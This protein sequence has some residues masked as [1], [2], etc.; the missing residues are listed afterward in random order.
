MEYLEDALRKIATMYVS[1]LK[2]N[3]AAD[4]TVASKKLLNSI[5]YRI[6]DKGFDLLSEK[7]L[8]TV[9]EGK[10]PTSKNPSPEMVR[11]IVSWMQYKRIPIR[12][13]KGRFKRQTPV[14]Y[15]RAAFGIAKQINKNQTRNKY[16]W[17]GS[18]VIDRSFRQ[19]EGKIDEY[20]VVALKESIDELI[21]KLN[22]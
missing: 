12:G 15:K 20:L 9:S 22:K 1:K 2:E 4:G 13:A 11:S 19:L 14:N 17:Q 18:D 7:H 3:I 21:V 16:R 5:D 8:G 6:T 10:K